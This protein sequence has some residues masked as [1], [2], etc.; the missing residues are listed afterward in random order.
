MSTNYEIFTKIEIS[1][2]ETITGDL[3]LLHTLINFLYEDAAEK[4]AEKIAKLH[5]S[6][7]DFLVII[8][9]LFLKFEKNFLNVEEEINDDKTLMQHFNLRYFNYQNYSYTG[10]IKHLVQS[11]QKILEKPENMICPSDKYAEQFQLNPQK[12]T[13]EV[14]EDLIEAIR[15]TGFIIYRVGRSIQYLGKVITKVYIKQLFEALGEK[16]ESIIESRNILWKLFCNSKLKD[17]EKLNGRFEQIEVILLLASTHYIC[18]DDNLKLI[19]SGSSLEELCWNPESE[20]L[21]N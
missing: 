12:F 16:V 17:D 15:F 19:E 14:V 11:L 20:F 6:D 10:E 4:V 8:E 5:S 9:K 7:K 1:T 2:L 18:V 13:E 3:E 21:E